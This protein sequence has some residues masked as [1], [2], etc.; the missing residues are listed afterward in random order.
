MDVNGLYQ[1]EPDKHPTLY[2]HSI[3]QRWDHPAS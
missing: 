1:I 3:P 2:E